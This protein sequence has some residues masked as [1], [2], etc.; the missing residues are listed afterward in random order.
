M[1]CVSDYLEPNQ[2]ERAL[3]KTAQLYAWSLQQLKQPVPAPLQEAADNQY[4]R[5]DYVP[6]LC[7]LLKGLKPKQREEL[8]YDARSKEARALA[9]WWEKHQAAD[10][11]RAKKEA[12]ETRRKNLAQ[13]ALAKLT[14]AEKRALRLTS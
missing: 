7:E 8:V 14:P 11:E 5:A 9:D 4:C 6:H 3:Q 10:K 2:R 12:Q 1:P 13:K